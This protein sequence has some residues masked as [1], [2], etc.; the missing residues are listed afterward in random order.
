[1]DEEK[2]VQVGMGV[3]GTQVKVALHRVCDP[4]ECPRSQSQT[5]GEVLED[6]YPVVQ[7]EGQEAVEQLTDRH[8]EESI[9][10]IQSATPRGLHY[11]QSD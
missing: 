4:I 5:K 10:Q 8:M 9:L 11:A 7:D 2:V 6:E 3:D 1:M